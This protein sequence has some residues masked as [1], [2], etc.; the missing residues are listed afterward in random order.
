MLK[1]VK[2]VAIFLVL[3]IFVSASCVFADVGTYVELYRDGRILG[4][5]GTNV[6]IGGS[7][8]SVFF[9]PA[10][11]S[12]MKRSEGWEV[13]LITL[14]VGINSKVVDFVKDFK[15]QVLDNDTEDKEQAVF[16]LLDKYTGE[17]FSGEENL[18]ISF[19]R[20]FKNFA[21]GIGVFERIALAGGVHEGFGTAGVLEV[22]NYGF[23]GSFLGLSINMFK[24]RVHIG[25]DVKYVYTAYLE[26]AFRASELIDHADNL[27]DY[28]NDELLKKGGSVVFDA[29]IIFT[30]FPNSLLNPSFG[31]SVMNIGDLEVNSTTVIPQ[32]VNIGF[33]IRSRL[34][35]GSHFFQNIA[36]GIDLRDIT[37]NYKEDED[38]GKRLYMGGEM[39]VFKSSH[40]TFTIRGGFYQG[41]PSFG[42][43]L[44][45]LFIDA[46]F[47]SYAEELGKYA[48]ERKSRNY[49]VELGIKW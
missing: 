17:V 14:N 41:Y 16:D 18:M 44:H 13:N 45:F 32:T 21:L 29:G 34:F 37:K 43:E 10:G 39:D 28:I 7:V 23:V 36:L 47:V 3:M 30:P 48:G 2:F 15:D 6:A 33:A 5:G 24:N 1:R 40:L 26:H 19:A 35:K 25:T 22:K 8:T 27:D 9:N 38:W 11:L 49:L 42:A 46:Q 31:I 20:P 4:M 12:L